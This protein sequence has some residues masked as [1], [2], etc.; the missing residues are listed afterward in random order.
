MNN[1]LWW[2][3]LVAQVLTFSCKTKESVVARE[4]KEL[5]HRSTR[6][7]LDSMKAS[8]IQYQW[9][10]LKTKI[11]FVNDTLS[12]EFKTLIRI[13]KDS[14]LWLSVTP[15]LGIE[16]AR[17]F[18][19]PDT[20]IF[21]DRIHKKYF[22]GHYDFFMEKYQIDIDFY[23]IQS[24]LTGSSIEF[25]DDERVRSGADRES[26]LYFISTNKKRKVKKYFKKEKEKK[27]K[28]DLQVIWLEPNH[29]KITRLFLTDNT[30]NQTLAC[31]Y[32]DFIL[33]DQQLFPGKMLF[34]I[35]S[36]KDIKL[37]V[38]VDKITLDAEYNLSITIPEKYEPMEK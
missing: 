27:I 31:E 7:L 37:Q 35:D 5:P 32:G 17:L 8:E 30:F 4:K 36:Q 10:G 38:V 33:Q 1:R 20:I 13:K 2:F 18:L 26:G 22:A 3:V 19:T 9:I 29:F 12:E 15:L 21:I 14:M 25:D 34:F 24:L 11:T 6:A 28:N 16:A 23:T